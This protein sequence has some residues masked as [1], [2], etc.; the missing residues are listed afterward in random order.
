MENIFEKTQNSFMGNNLRNIGKKENF[1][2]LK[3][4]FLNICKLT[5]YLLVNNFL[6]KLVR[7]LRL[8]TKQECLPTAPNQ[9]VT[10]RSSH[11]HF[12]SA[13]Q[14]CPTLCDPMN[15]STP[16]LPVH[17]QLPEFTETHVH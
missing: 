3:K 7:K 9:F 4:K 10:G 5:S 16:G 11:Y 6:A 8:G 1:S 14:S 12:S 17:H 2:C 15:H 13:T